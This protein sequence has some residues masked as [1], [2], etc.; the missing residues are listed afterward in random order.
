[1]RKRQ[2]LKCPRGRLI[3]LHLLE[4][5]S[6]V[7]TN[8]FVVPYGKPNVLVT[9]EGPL[10]TPAKRRRGPERGNIPLR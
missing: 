10:G 4:E 9:K 7:K 3:G 6:G 8:G 5:M 1:M 2:N